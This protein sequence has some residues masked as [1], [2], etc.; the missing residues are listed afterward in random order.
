[1]PR[2]SA[3]PDPVRL[4][5]LLVV[6]W[7][8]VLAGHRPITQIRPLLAPALYR[9]LCDQLKPRSVGSQPATRVRAVFSC[10]PSATTLEASVLVEQR[11]RV[12]ALAVRV[13]RHQGMWRAVEL[14]A[15]EAGLRPL[16][17]VPQHQVAIPPNGTWP[18]TMNTI[19]AP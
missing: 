13:E 4:A 17:T 10:S 5:E 1:M 12:T 2:R 15:P 14:T 7:L 19:H 18:T 9:Q 3:K 8:E 11:Q 16:G 6:T